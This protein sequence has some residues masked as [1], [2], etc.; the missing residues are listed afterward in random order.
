MLPLFECAGILDP[1]SRY[2]WV[3]TKPTSASGGRRQQRQVACAYRVGEGCFANLGYPEDIAR[4]PDAARL[5]VRLTHEVLQAE[6]VAGL[7]RQLRAGLASRGDAPAALLVDVESIASTIASAELVQQKL[8]AFFSSTAPTL[9]TPGRAE[10]AA[11]EA[12]V[13]TYGGGA[14]RRLQE[15]K[16]IRR[17]HRMAARNSSASQ[18]AAEHSTSVRSLRLGSRSSRGGRGGGRGGAKGSRAL[19]GRGGARGSGRGGRGILR[20]YAP[21]PLNSHLGRWGPVLRRHTC[22]DGMMMAPSRNPFVC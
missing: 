7:L 22:G 1:M 20:G 4:T 2:A 17:W 10:P 18:P 6:G 9:R 11:A 8:G 13:S 21:G 16:V 15:L 14:A 5:T 3:L 12:E 19:S